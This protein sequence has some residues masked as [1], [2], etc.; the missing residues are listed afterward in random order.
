MGS[1]ENMLGP[2]RQGRDRYNCDAMLKDFKAFVMRGNVLDLA[3]AVVVGGAFNKIVTSFVDDVLMP[4]LGLLLGR[5]DFREKFIDLSGQG[6]ATLA[7]AQAMG[8]A[9]LRYGLFIN[10][11][12]NFLIVALAIF[13]VLRSIR[14]FLPA[15]PA[16]DGRECPLCLS[17]I[18]LKAKRCRHCGSEVAP[19]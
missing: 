19:V 5:V 1:K 12:V 10:A 3:V 15:P 2:P 14:R 7:Q 17:L 13:L 6:P 16:P 9:V 8:A 4:P 11:I 18:P